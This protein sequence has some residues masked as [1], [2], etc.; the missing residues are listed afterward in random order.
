MIDFL[1]LTPIIKGKNENLFYLLVIS[2]SII[3]AKSPIVVNGHDHQ[4]VYWAFNHQFDKAE[5]LT[6]EKIAENPNIP[7]YYFLKIVTESLRHLADSDQF[8]YEKDMNTEK[9]KMKN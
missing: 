1:I 3:F 4:I 5:Q 8:N 2:S 7:K 6:T 9:R